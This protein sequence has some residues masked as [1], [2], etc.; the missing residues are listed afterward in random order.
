MWNDICIKDAICSKYQKGSSIN[1]LGAEG[2]LK[3]KNPPPPVTASV[4]FSPEERYQN[5]PQEII[6]GR[7]MIWGGWR[8]NWEK[9]EGASPGKNFKFQKAFPLKK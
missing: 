1:D 8:K 4:I 7:L 5:P 6:N 2:K 9:I 3:R